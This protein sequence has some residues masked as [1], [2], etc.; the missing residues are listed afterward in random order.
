MKIFLKNNNKWLYFILTCFISWPVWLAGKIIL[1]EK[2]TIITLIL[3]AFGPFIASL[4]LVSI[5]D[6]RSGLKEWFKINFNFRIKIIWYMLGGIIL[7]F[8]IAG[9]HHLIYL[10]LGGKSGIEFSTDW[11]IYFVYLIPTALLTGGNEEPGWRGYITPVLLER[12]HPVV[13]CT[14][15][16]LG[17][18]VWHLPMYFLGGWGG[19]DQ[20]FF[21]LLIYCIPLSMI[22]TWLYYKSKRSIIPVMLLHAG[23]NVVF[24]YFPME[25]KLF[26]YMADEFTVIKTIVYWL[27]AI[28]LLIISKGSLG[29]KKPVS[30][31]ER[32]L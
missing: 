21:W 4:I 18:A 30:E 20:P 26:D 13:V 2:L 24:R 5:T 8:L 32:S 28:L 17:W 10:W 23:T 9:V 1:P 22:L 31:N 6:E 16:G 27:F 19:S 29:F 11:L 15:V 12:F 25:T 7:P 3:G 14:F